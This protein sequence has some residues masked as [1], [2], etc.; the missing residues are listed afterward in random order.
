[1][2]TLVALQSRWFH[3]PRLWYIEED[4]KTVSLG[5]HSMSIL[6]LCLT[7]LFEPRMYQQRVVTAAIVIVLILL[8]AIIVWEKLS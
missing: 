5:K 6:K 1:M 7:D 2:T 8:I 4:D 3:R